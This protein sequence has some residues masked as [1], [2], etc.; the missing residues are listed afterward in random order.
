M[1][2]MLFA[3]VP[4]SLTNAA[5]FSML[6]PDPIVLAS[7][8]AYVKRTHWLLQS[9]LCLSSVG[10]GT[11][12]ACAVGSMMCSV[13]WSVGCALGKG[14]A[15]SSK[16]S[17]TKLEPAVAGGGETNRQFMHSVQ[18]P[19]MTSSMKGLDE[20]GPQITLLLRELNCGNTICPSREPQKC[21]RC[22]RKKSFDT[23]R[24]Y[25]PIS[26]EWEHEEWKQEY[27]LLQVT[28]ADMVTSLS[29]KTREKSLF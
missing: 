19:Q 4:A 8:F 27:T 21:S 3:L 11:D 2:K 24:K 13:G 16:S 29:N 22:E 6:L 26:L 14:Q 23:R 1:K 9:C 5:P 18:Q 20:P 25:C 28:P 12:S 15:L 10:K 7:G 17:Q